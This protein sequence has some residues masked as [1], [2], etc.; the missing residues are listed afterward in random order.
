ML[1]RGTAQELSFRVACEPGKPI[2]RCAVGIFSIDQDQSSASALISY[3]YLVLR[4]LE[5]SVRYHPLTSSPTDFEAAVFAFALAYTLRESKNWAKLLHRM[6]EG[7]ETPGTRLPKLLA[8]LS[9][10]VD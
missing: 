10:F 4:Y 7:S 3:L 5:P 1:W 8:L 6:F 2:V 9:D